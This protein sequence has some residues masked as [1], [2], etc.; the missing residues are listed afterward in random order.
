MPRELIADRPGHT[1]LRE[2]DEALLK[3]DQVRA[4]TLFSAVKHGTE[5]RGFQANTLD[6]SDIFSWEWRMH[7]R[8]Q[9]QKDVFPKRLGNIYVAEVADIGQ[10]VSNI[11]IGDRIFGHGSVRE[12]HT[13]SADRVEKAPEGVAK[14]HGDRPRGRCSRWRQRCQYSHW[15]SRRSLWFGCNWT[16]DRTTRSH[17]RRTLGRGNRPH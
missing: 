11:R 13:L 12:T 17:R 5:F 7:M 14:S 4:K 2:Y 16:D 8:G 10:N 6:A 15:G 9:K 3:P 1:A